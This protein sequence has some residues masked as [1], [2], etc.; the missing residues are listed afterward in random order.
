M[1]YEIHLQ[2]ASYFSRKPILTDERKESIFGR[3]KVYRFLNG[4][5]K[6]FPSKA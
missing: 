4:Y 6:H 1:F 3:N 5:Y 2:W